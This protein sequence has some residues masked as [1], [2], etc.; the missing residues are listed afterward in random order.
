MLNEF[1][2]KIWRIEKKPDCFQMQRKKKLFK[3]IS[4]T[5]SF[6]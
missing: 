3:K 6:D 5:L 4:I 1:Q 2:L